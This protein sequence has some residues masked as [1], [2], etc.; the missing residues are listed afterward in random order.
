MTLFQSITFVICSDSATGILL[1]DPPLSRVS[2]YDLHQCGCRKTRCTTPPLY[3]FLLGSK[4]SLVVPPFIQSRSPVEKRLK[5]QRIFAILKGLDGIYTAF[6]SRR[7][8]RTLIPSHAIHQP[9]PGYFGEHQLARPRYP[10]SIGSIG[11]GQRRGLH[12]RGVQQVSTVFS[13]LSKGSS[14]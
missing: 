7:V 9:S 14:V 10:A 3:N 5:S 4:H 8:S 12:V 11:A 2:I 6:P 1:Q 13:H